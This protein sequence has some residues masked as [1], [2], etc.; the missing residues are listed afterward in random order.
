MYHIIHYF[1]AFVKY[2]YLRQ[3]IRIDDPEKAKIHLYSAASSKLFLGLAAGA[4]SA[5][6]SE[7]APTS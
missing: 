1:R 5:Q 2:F 4:S 7:T 6:P 3:A